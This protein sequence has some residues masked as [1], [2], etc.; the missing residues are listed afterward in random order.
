MK[1]EINYKKKT[2]K[3]IYMWRFKNMLLN[4]SQRKTS[5]GKSKNILRQMKMETT[6]YKNLW[7]TAKAVLEGSL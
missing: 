7:S 6:I 5:K 4:M 2:G 1:L 3:F